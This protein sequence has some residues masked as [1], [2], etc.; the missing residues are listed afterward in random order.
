MI[1]MYRDDEGNLKGD[2]RIGYM[3][4][5]SVDMAL[6]MLNDSEI[7]PGYKIKVTQAEFQMK[8]EN[9]VPTKRAKLDKVE[10]LRYQAL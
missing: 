5:E 7:R 2:A 4:E 1:K 10:K 9:Y 3:M 8:G 6:E